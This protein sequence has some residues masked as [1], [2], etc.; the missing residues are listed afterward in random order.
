MPVLTVARNKKV[1]ETVRRRPGRPRYK[2]GASAESTKQDLLDAAIYLFSRYGYDGVSTG[3]I[4]KRANMTQSMVHY[5]FGSK[6]KVWKAAAH[7]IMRNRGKR[8]QQDQDALK[9]L[10]PVERLNRLTRLLISANAKDQ[11]YVQMAVHEGTIS[12][13]RLSWMVKNYYA[14][15][16]GVFDQAIAD[17]IEEGSIVDLPVVEIT[18]VITSVSLLFSLQAMIK[19]IYGID[20]GDDEVV[21]SFSDTLVRVLFHGL[22]VEKPEDGEPVPDS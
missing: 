16:Y 4:A 1:K 7:A 22:L 19:E 13:P 2:E 14:A 10:P 11:D 12:G 3:D 15:G 8:F 21:E 20:F 17:A 6:M 5:H 18:N 9:S